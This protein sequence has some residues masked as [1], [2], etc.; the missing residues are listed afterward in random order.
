MPLYMCKDRQRVLDATGNV[1]I[2][3]GPGSGK[4]T[5]ALL[6]A[7][8]RIES[9]LLAGESVLFLSFSRAAVA[10]AAE[11]TKAAGMPQGVLRYLS[12]QTFHSFFWEILKAYGYLLGAPRQ[13]RLLLPHDEAV[14]RDGVEE[15]NSEWLELREKLF[16]ERG[17]VV[18][19]LFAPKV[20]A[21]L[22]ASARIRDIIASR[23]P[24]IIVDEAQDTA[25]DQWQIVQ[26]LSQGPQLVC[27][28][29]LEQQIYDFRPGVSS[30]RVTQIMGV[31]N[32]VRVDLEGQNH[33]SPDS[34]IVTFGNDVLNRTPRG[35]AYKGVSRFA[36]QAK[37]EARDKAIRISIGL[38]SKRAQQVLGKAPDSIG[39][40]ASWGKGVVIIS[41]ALTGDGSNRI[42]HKVNIDEAAAILSSRLI[43]YLMEPRA[44]SSIEL[45][46]L[47]EALDLAQAVF[48]CKGTKGATA[49]AAALSKQGSQA[50]GGK[51]PRG[52]SAGDALRQVIRTLKN[53]RL[54]G[55]PKADWICVRKLLVQGPAVLGTISEHASDLPLFQRGTA[56]S[57]GLSDLW[58]T[59]GTY[60]GARMIL[61]AV[62]A[63]DQLLSG[64]SEPKG[65]H[66]MTLHKAKGKEF[67]AV[68]IFDDANN[69]PLVLRE[70]AHPHTRSR[71]LLRVGITRA[72]HHVL[73]LTDIYSPT[74]LLH[75]HN[76]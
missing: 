11:A 58:Q 64:G 56:I 23:Y 41:R 45:L 28:A 76:L 39:F 37:Q 8:K 68:V 54:T 9:G 71:R 22:A 24:L 12:V 74:P 16:R 13:L 60:T 10:R 26:H 31:L 14:F 17:L 73:L 19:D 53:T 15:E 57:T 40:L 6:K 61:D 50:R 43:A 27:L 55:V 70:D 66:V 47:A 62:I 38:V 48:R 35:S 2:T 34:E 42:N 32:P 3:G 51:L 33:R 20:C 36:F 25:D 21:L 1:L 46:D 67:D 18:F 7:R 65:I 59:D 30:E 49:T 69:S 29:D 72:K 4:T 75:G 63:Q 52:G 5:I 44:Q